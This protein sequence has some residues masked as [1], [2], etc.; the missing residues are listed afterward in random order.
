MQ[1]QYRT[2]GV[3]EQALI[4]VAREVAKQL[5]ERLDQFLAPLLVVLDASLEKR[6][7][8]T[9]LDLVVSLVQLRH[10]EAG[11]VLSEGGAMLLSPKPGPAESQAD[12]PLVAQPELGSRAHRAG[13]LAKNTA[14]SAGVGKPRRDRIEPA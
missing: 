9:V 14:A 2:H 3:T 8:R 4:A 6:L 10:R 13:S 11:V 12:W 1:H 7:V 5:V